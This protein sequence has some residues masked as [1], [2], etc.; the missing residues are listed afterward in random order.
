MAFW[1]EKRIIKK[2]INIL[3]VSRVYALSK[4]YFK[5]RTILSAEYISVEGNTCKACFDIWTWRWT[6]IKKNSK[7]K[8]VKYK[9]AVNYIVHEYIK[10]IY[11]YK[12]SITY[13]LYSPQYFH[14]LL[15]FVPCAPA[16][17]GFMYVLAVQM[18]YISRV[19][20]VRDHRGR[21]RHF[22]LT[23]GQSR[24][25][26]HFLLNN[27]YYSCFIAKALI[28]KLIF[29]WIIIFYIQVFVKSKLVFPPTLFHWNIFTHFVNFN[30]CSERNRVKFN[31]P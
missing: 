31:K 14:D 21:K 11:L 26:K 10:N 18:L 1:V 19:L 3:H 2:H 29:K 27:L 28:S 4:V 24:K 20:I 23:Y 15:F 22:R 9:H 7:S 5:T 12:Y 16:H 13:I 6:S 17:E 25:S 30:L 8:T